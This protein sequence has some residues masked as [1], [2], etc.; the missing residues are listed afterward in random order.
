MYACFSR[1]S[2]AMVKETEYYDILGVKPDASASH[3]KKAYYVK[4]YLDHVFYF[5]GSIKWFTN[6]TCSQIPPPEKTKEKILLLYLF[7]SHELKLLA[8]S[9][10]DLWKSYEN[11][12][13]N[14]MKT[15]REILQLLDHPF[16]PTLYPYLQRISTR[17]GMFYAAE[18]F[19][20]LEYLH[21]LGV[22]YRDLKPENIMVHED[23][24]IML[25]VFDLSIRC[26]PNP[27][28]LKPSSPNIDHPKDPQSSCIN[29]FCLQPSWHVPC[30]T[31]R[32]LAVPKLKSEIVPQLLV[33]PTGARSN[34]FVGTHECLRSSLLLQ[35]HR[36]TVTSLLLLYLVPSECKSC[37]NLMKDQAKRLFRTM[38][39]GG[40][41]DLDVLI[42][43]HC[44][45][46]SDHSKNKIDGTIKGSS[47]HR[48]SPKDEDRSDRDRH[49]SSRETRGRDKDKGM[50]E[51]NGKCRDIGTWS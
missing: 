8:A 21:M 35:H 18:I 37:G 41:A 20:A 6:R 26:D 7:C 27:T 39:M 22:I 24:H 46:E 11:G 40:N 14:L 4:V 25:T 32:V 31:P 1:I 3:I 15:E 36:F 2:S 38:Y 51:K 29:P 16:L 30:F 23:C 12:T 13:G 47:R 10:E 49:R 9:K 28:L 33:E 48:S 19:L 45:L 34:S 43:C 17:L 5:N 50:E 42:M 44:Y